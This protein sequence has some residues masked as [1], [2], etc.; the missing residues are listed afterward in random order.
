METCLSLMASSRLDCVRGEARL[1]SSAS[2]M[3]VK[4]GPS[5]KAKLPSFGL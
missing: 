1:I 3:L 4:I 5:L 2:R